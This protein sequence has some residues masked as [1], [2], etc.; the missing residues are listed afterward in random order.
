MNGRDVRT[1]VLRGSAVIAAATGVMNGATYAFTLLCAHRLGPADYGVFAAML[2]LVIVVN[3]VS[4]G[5]QATGARRVAAAPG[6]RQLIEARLMSTSVRAGLV[7]AAA[8]LAGTP[9]MAAALR[10]DS[11]ATG[12]L[13]AVPAF[14]FSV[15]GGQAG[16][17]QGE[18]RWLPLAAVFASLGL[19][20]LGLGA[21]AVAIDSS[22][23][24]AM[25][26]GVAAASIV[27]VVVGALA[28]RHARSSIS[29][30][31]QPA[32][33]RTH[34]R[35]GREALLS[36]HA[37]LAFFALATV[38]VLVARAVL[39]EHEA[40]LYAAGLILVKGVQFLPQFV[41][42]VAYPAM[43]RHGGTNR[44]HLWGLGLVLAIGF[45]AMV[46]VRVG[47][48]LAL[49]LVG[50][51][52]YAAVEPLLW[53]FAGVGTLLAAVQLLVYTSIARLRHGAVSLLWAAVAVIVLAS[54]VITSG[55]QLLWVVASV[56]A[57]LLMVLVL[58][59]RRADALRA[60]DRPDPMAVGTTV[61]G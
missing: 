60:T 43:A 52:Q 56:D 46:L 6:D 2:G 31:G 51:A 18:G 53:L 28:L 19:A 22:A 61:T 34:S 37:L 16:I 20:R 25:V 40:G 24:A 9:L 59:G 44:V 15:M 48:H 47:G 10:L 11:W 17:L 41:S 38:D 23:L 7:L 57:A 30:D 3:V 12:A 26:G 45:V 4:L 54:Q 55:Q 39:E 49:P 33:G 58:L 27:P 29:L 42:V 13:L 35:M 8:C 1:S 14:C 32:T 50:G 21:V 5:L 36:S